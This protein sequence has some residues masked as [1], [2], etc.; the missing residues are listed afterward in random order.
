MLSEKMQQLSRYSTSNLNVKWK[1]SGRITRE[2]K[3]PSTH[4]R[5]EVHGTLRYTTIE[6]YLA[7]KTNAEYLVLIIQLLS[8]LGA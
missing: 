8:Y 7:R 6:A 4:T 3:Y 5:L 1:V 2:V